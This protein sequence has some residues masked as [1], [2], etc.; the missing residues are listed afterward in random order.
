[1]V[2]DTVLCPIQGLVELSQEEHCRRWSAEWLHIPP[3]A[4]RE[5]LVAQPLCR[6]YN[7][8][9]NGIS[10]MFAYRWRREICEY[11]SVLFS[12]Y[13]RQIP[14]STRT[15]HTKT[16]RAAEYR[17]SRQHHFYI[18]SHFFFRSSGIEHIPYTPSSHYFLFEESYNLHI[19]SATSHSFTLRM[20]SD[21][22]HYLGYIFHSSRHCFKLV[23]LGISYSD[24]VIP[25]PY[26]SFVNGIH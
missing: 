9:E 16:Q 20:S 13:E 11:N 18:F 15:R 23:A 2:T 3:Q 22:I 12:T 21:T 24:C 17:T 26:L 19:L 7:T 10:N 8:T 14:E 25:H 5:G 1:M 6:G 4:D